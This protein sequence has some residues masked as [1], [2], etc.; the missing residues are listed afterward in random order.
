MTLLQR[1]NLDKRQDREGEKGGGEKRC[2]GAYFWRRTL[3]L[4]AVDL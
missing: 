3:T 1:R 4:T 2:R